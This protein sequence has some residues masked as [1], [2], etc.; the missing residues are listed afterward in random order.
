MDEVEGR[1][2]ALPFPHF[3][4]PSVLPV[5]AARD[6]LG[7]LE[8]SEWQLFDGDLY[9]F[10]VPSGNDDGALAAYAIVRESG[11][12]GR[13]SRLAAIELGIVVDDSAAIEAHRYTSGSGIGVHSDANVGEFRFVVHLNRSWG[14]DDGG[15]LA[16]SASADMRDARVLPPMH[17]TGIGFATGRA[18][19][20][21]VTERKRA[22][23]YLL[24]FRFGYKQSSESG[25]DAK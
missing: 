2:F 22:E 1:A 7:L 9:S 12:L 21:A 23:S 13:I 20:H 8:A 5:E 19:Y 24:V 25:R 6:A 4:V 14:V 17:N 16:L 10:F 15:V 18:T 3:L 11:V